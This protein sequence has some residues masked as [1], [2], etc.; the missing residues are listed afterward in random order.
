MVSAQFWHGPGRD[1]DERYRIAATADGRLLRER[2]SL[3][4]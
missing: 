3:E 1:D 4:S 2:A